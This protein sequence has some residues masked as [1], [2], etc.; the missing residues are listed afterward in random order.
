MLQTRK[1]CQTAR[2][3]FTLIELLVVIAIIAILIGLLLP[4]VQK[5]R[6][7][8]AR[9]SC[10]NNLKQ[11]ALAIHNYHDARSELPPGGVTPGDCCGT[12]S[13][14]NWAIYILPFIEQDNLF[15]Q[16][17]D[18]LTN[19]DPANAVIRAA[20]V[21]TYECPSDPQAG[22]SETPASGPGSGLQYV[23]GSYRG[24]AGRS[25]ALDSYYDNTPVTAQIQQWRGPL[26]SYASKTEKKDNL[27]GFMDGTSNT[28]MVGE[29]TTNTTTNRGTF[30]AYTYTCFAIASAQTM[31]GTLLADYN[32]CGTSTGNS[33]MCKRGW[34]SNHSGGIM[35]VLG[36]G[37]VRMINTNI[38]MTI[39][40][41]LGSIAGGEVVGNF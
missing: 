37:S 5:V 23:H 3:G 34:G 26:H 4:A 39:F 8:A 22:R 35:F 11:I 13:F 18:T 2:P 38:N 21:K 16:Y 24:M 32:A 9:M 19:E 25:D 36:D 33:N 17:N 27:T 10:S 30:W 1:G 14:G 12:Q 15:K 29:Y 31:S 7:A 41:S 40:A 20:R 28:L 6:E